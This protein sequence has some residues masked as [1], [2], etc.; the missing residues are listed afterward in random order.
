MIINIVNLEYENWTDCSSNEDVGLR[1][2]V[3]P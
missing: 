3:Y 2:C 1:T